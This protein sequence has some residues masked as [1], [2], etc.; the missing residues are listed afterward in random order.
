VE[1]FYET[2]ATEYQRGLYSFS[3]H[4]DELKDATISSG[5]LL[6]YGYQLAFFNQYMSFSRLL[7]SCTDPV[8]SN[9][10]KKL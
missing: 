3:T 2:L 4:T 1:K 6:K 5:L 7:S 9:F 10:I 8:V